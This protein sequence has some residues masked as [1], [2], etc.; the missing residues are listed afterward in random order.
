MF[1]LKSYVYLSVFVW[2]GDPRAK[3]DY[4]N[5]FFKYLFNQKYKTHFDDNLKL[6]MKKVKNILFFYTNIHHTDKEKYIKK[7]Y[8]CIS[9]L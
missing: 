3:Y 8:Y 4:K 6:S 9:F 2:P 7:M 1:P 5:R